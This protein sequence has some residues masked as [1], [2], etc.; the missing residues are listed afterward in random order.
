MERYKCEGSGVEEMWEYVTEM[1]IKHITNIKCNDIITSLYIAME[2][3]YKR[4]V[5]INHSSTTTD[6]NVAT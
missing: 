4:H 6:S 3:S 5:A 2:I 1:E